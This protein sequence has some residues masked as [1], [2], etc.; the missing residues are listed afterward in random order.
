LDGD[1]KR[2]NAHTNMQRNP[3]PAIN[4][5]ICQEMIAIIKSGVTPPEIIQNPS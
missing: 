1:Q 5:V 3:E 2:Y 4:P